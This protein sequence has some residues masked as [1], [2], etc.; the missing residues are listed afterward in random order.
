[1]L[2]CPVC[3]ALQENSLSRPETP[4]VSLF[5]LPSLVHI[6]QDTMASLLLMASQ[7]T[8]RSMDGLET[9]QLKAT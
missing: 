8:N 7:R 1:M 6:L 9:F 2:L 5:P 4:P 3:Q